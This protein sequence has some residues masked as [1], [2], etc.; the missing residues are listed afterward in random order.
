MGNTE[1]KKTEAKPEFSFRN[2]EKDFI[3]KHNIQPE[4][5]YNKLFSAHGKK[6]FKMIKPELELKAMEDHVRT[7][8]VIGVDP[9]DQ[10]CKLVFEIIWNG[11]LKYREMSFGCTRYDVPWLDFTLEMS[12]IT[13][14]TDEELAQ[15]A[16]A[17][18]KALVTD[19]RAVNCCG[20]FHDFKRQD[21][22]YYWII[23]QEWEGL[24][25]RYDSYPREYS[26]KNGNYEKLA[27]TNYIE[28]CLPLL[29]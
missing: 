6:I 21:K 15:M 4:E 24:R 23:P 28:R 29:N 12:D 8:N 20:P 27:L 14:K 10:F 18:F 2:Y 11:Y 26:I 22:L 25:S 9:Y 7:F 13:S 1:F 3:A 5:Y 17:R 19:R 16:L